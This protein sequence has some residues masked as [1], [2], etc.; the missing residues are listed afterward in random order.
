MRWRLPTLPSDLTDHHERDQQRLWLRRKTGGSFFKKIGALKLY[1]NETQKRWLLVGALLALTGLIGLLMQIYRGMTVLAPTTGGVYIEGVVGQI[2]FLNPLYASAN[3]LDESLTKLIYAPLV[4]FLPDGTVQGVVAEKWEKQ[5]NKYVFT[6]KNNL[7]WH[8][9]VK[10]TAEDVVFTFNA[11]ADDSWQSPLRYVYKDLKVSASGDNVVVIE[12]S[13]PSNVV[14][15]L[16]TLGLISKHVWSE[17]EPANAVLS[18][19]NSKPVGLGAYKFTRAVRGDDGN[20]KS[21]ELARDENGPEQGLLDKIVFRVYNDSNSALTDVLNKQ[22]DAF[23]GLSSDQEKKV[24]GQ[25]NW[26][27]VNLTLPQFTAVFFRPSS[28]FLNQP[29]VR[30]ALTLATNRSELTSIFGSNYKLISDLKASS[31]LPFDKA[32]AAALLDQAGYSITGPDNIRRKK[33]IEASFILTTADDPTFLA[34]ATKLREEWQSLGIKVGLSVVPTEDIRAT[35]LEVR[36]YDALLFSEATASDGDLYPLWHS[37]QR[38]YPGINLSSVS[39]R[40]IDG[41]LEQARVVSPEQR[42]G[43]Y[44]Q[45]VAEMKNDPPAVWLGQASLAMI[46][47]KKVMGADNVVITDRNDRMYLLLKWYKKTKR[48]WK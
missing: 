48:V 15:S 36:K 35:I 17:V 7:A 40:K 39:S 18:P 31:D 16:A 19:L 26:S 38:F 2:R 32:K 34:L 41:W 6:L 23:E 27:V 45:V 13:E 4:R 30:Q 14:L 22:L 42:D 28:D 1:L 21:L 47:S 44:S 3:P 46:I 29:L 25:G 33:K 10:F 9:G 20:I 5:G 43:L 24:E 12:S 11:V 8:D 37:S